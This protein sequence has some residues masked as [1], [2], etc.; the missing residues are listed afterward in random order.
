MNVLYFILL[1]LFWGGSFIAIKFSLEGFHP[2]LAVTLRIVI[3]FGLAALYVVVK[4]IAWPSKRVMLRAMIAGAIGL[5]IPWA[6]LFYGEQYVEPALA[7]IINAATPL[8]TILFAMIML[9]RKEEPI[10]ANRILGIVLGFVGIGVIFGPFVTMHSYQGIYGLLAIL[11]MAV[12]YAFSLIILKGVTSKAGNMMLLFCECAGGA[13]VVIPLTVFTGLK[14]PL[15]TGG[16]LLIPTISILYLAVVSSALAMLIFYSL[17]RNTGT[18]LASAVTYTI[19]IVSIA[20]DWIVLDKWIGS[21]ALFGAL[22]IFAALKLIRKPIV[23]PA[24][25]D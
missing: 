12:G 1:S 6:L 14:E 4:K 7:S 11:G 24:V 17:L 22:I 15:L 16:D 5:G 13:A 20:L 25:A 10:T 3:A 23:S 18:L 9:S 2:F 8:F 19:P 21:H